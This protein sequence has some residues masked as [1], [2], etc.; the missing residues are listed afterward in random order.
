MKSA[1]YL[2]S[3]YSLLSSMCQIERSVKKAK[4]LGYTSLALVDKNNLSGAKSFYNACVKESIKPIFGLEFDL[5]LDDRIYSIILYA[6]NDDGY[7]NLMKLSSIINKQDNKY[8]DIETLNMYREHNFLVLPSDNMPLT[9]VYGQKGDVN[10]CLDY[11][12]RVFGKDYLIGLVDH[13]VLANI[14]Q[15]EHLRDIYKQRGIKCFALCR[16]LYLEKDDYKEYEVLKAIRDKKILNENSYYEKGR[17]FLNNDELSEL[18][19]E[20]E[21]MNSD[22]FASYCNVKLEFKTSLPSYPTPNGISS[23]DY[24]VALCKEGLKR[25]LKNNVNETYKKRLDYELNV[26]LKMQ[27]ENYFLIVYDFILFAKKKGIMVGPGRG[28]A[29]GSLV[30]YCL[31]ITEIDPI[32][33][34]LLFERFLNPER[35]S[36]PDIDTDFPDNRRD[37]VVLYVKEKYGEDHVGHIVTLWYFEG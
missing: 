34:G 7:L 8:I 22:V 19:S 37:E 3:V 29:A 2:R 16:T 27:F 17:H 23:K 28:S 10:K 15:D 4:E 9:I 14:N 30:S 1:L 33:Y 36:M 6:K 13:N 24:L 5:K 12:E 21:L 20:S 18:Y 31:G 35:I 26:I 11:Q 32:K 25:R